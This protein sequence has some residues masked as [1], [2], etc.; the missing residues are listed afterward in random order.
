MSEKNE[1]S[2]FL[3]T[4]K[5]TYTLPPNQINEQKIITEIENAFK[6]CAIDKSG[7][8]WISSKNLHTILRTIKKNAKYYTAQIEEKDKFSLNDITYI[9]GSKIISIIDE[10]IQNTGDI[11]KSKNLKFS[12][13]LYG[14]IRD[15]SDVRL[16]R[17][18]YI[19]NLEKLVKKLK[20]ERIKKFKIGQDELTNEKLII[21]TSEFSHI[22]SCS[23]YPQF[24]DNIFNGHIVNKETHEII[25]ENN[26]ND[27]EE[28]FELCKTEKWNTDWYKDYKKMLKNL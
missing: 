13:D 11:K 17:V 5:I 7:H 14:T 28:L 27:E 9:K 12:Y 20:N 6:N 3:F 19:Q 16:L 8:I 10:R 2:N 25:T 21:K 24:S 22:R 18:E 1:L 15:C 23:I 4:Q 26:I